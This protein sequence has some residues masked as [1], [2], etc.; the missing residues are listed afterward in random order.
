MKVDGLTGTIHVGAGQRFGEV[1]WFPLWTAAGM[2]QRFA[3]AAALTF[4]ECASAEVDRL[5]VTNASDVPGLLIQGE[6]VRGGLQDRTCT[7]TVIVSPASSI[8]VPVACIEQGRW[9]PSGR[10]HRE[11]LTPPRIRARYTEARLRSAA[12]MPWETDQL[13]TWSEIDQFQRDGSQFAPTGSYHDVYEGRRHRQPTEETPRPLDGQRGVALGYAGQVRS[14]DLFGTHEDLVAVWDRLLDAARFEAGFA[15]DA[16]VPAARARRAVRA[17]TR[18][19][20]RTHRS[21][22][23]GEDLRAENE[24]LVA[25]GVRYE[26]GLAHLAAFVRDPALA[27]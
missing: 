11:S 18:L 17:L 26:D 15:P 7:T 12:D 1:T 2:T 6:T 20:F 23:L 5:M 24:H 4:D 9:T 25:N 19:Q 21:L 14:V 13:G 3:P 10:F 8:D 16:R 27:A 22:G